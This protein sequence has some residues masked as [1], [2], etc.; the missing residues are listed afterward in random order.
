MYDVVIEKTPDGEARVAVV[1]LSDMQWQP[2][3]RAMIESMKPHNEYTIVTAEAI[4]LGTLPTTG[5]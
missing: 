1:V 4:A 5:E 2:K 3:L